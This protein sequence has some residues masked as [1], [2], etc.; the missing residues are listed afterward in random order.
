MTPVPPAGA[1][2]TLPPLV[3]RAYQLARVTVLAGDAGAVLP[4]RRHSI[5]CSPAVAGVIPRAWLPWPACSAS[6]AGW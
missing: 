4:V 1:A 6:A 3:A 2:M 5:C